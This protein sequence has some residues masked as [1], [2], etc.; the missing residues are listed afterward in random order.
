M[1]LG[2]G[3]CCRG[4]EAITACNRAA[5]TSALGNTECQQLTHRTV[6]LPWCPVRSCPGSQEEAHANSHPSAVR[7]RLGCHAYCHLKHGRSGKQTLFLPNY[8]WP[9]QTEGPAFTFLLWL[10]QWNITRPRPHILL[11][12][13]FL[14]SS[15]SNRGHPLVQLS[16]TN[17]TFSTFLA[18][19]PEHIN[20]FSASNL[21]GNKC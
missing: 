16:H 12:K 10:S 21:S 3:A 18:I 1:G 5:C 14:V 11:S 2:C 19:Q 7:D 4:L 15:H 6:H 13:P 20:H 9:Y 8:L 17:L